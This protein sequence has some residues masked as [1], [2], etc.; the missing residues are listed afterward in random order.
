MCCLELTLFPKF[1]QGFPRSDIDIPVIL[2]ERRRLT[3]R[4]F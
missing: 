2:S 3:G 4:V 1:L